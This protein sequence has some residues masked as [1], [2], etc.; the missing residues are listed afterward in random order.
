VCTEVSAALQA[1]ASTA[2]SAVLRRGNEVLLVAVDE[3][4]H[5]SARPLAAQ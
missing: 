1:R 4:G 2:D 5:V 3:A